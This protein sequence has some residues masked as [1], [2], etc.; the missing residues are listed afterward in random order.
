VGSDNAR[1]LDIVLLDANLDGVDQVS[2]AL[3]GYQDLDAVHFI[4]HGTDAAVKLGDT[5]LNLDN[6]DGYAGAIAGWN[7][8]LADDA[9]MLFYGCELAQSEDGKSLVDALGALTGADVAASVDDTGSAALGGDWE[10]EY[11]TGTIEATTALSTVD[12][13]NWSGLLNTFTVTN[14]NDS[15]AG[16]LRQAILDANALGGV[17]T[18]VFNIAATDV[19]H[20]YYQD[21][22]IAGSLSNPSTTSLADGSIVD[23]DP[24]YPG[25][26]HSWYSIKL[27]SVLPDITDPVI[28][29][30]TTQPGFAGTPI[31]ELDGTSAGGMDPNGLTLNAGNSTVRGFV[32]NRFADDGIELDVAGG[33]TIEG[34]YIGT[35]VTG[36]IA[37]GNNY[38][39]SVKSDGNIIGGTNPGQRNIIS[40]NNNWGIGFYVAASNNTVQGNYIGTDVVGTS[41]LGNSGSGINLYNGAANNTIGGITAGTGNIIANS[42]GNGVTVQN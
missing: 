36:T 31:I 34:N 24:D 15:G 32:I 9:D 42:A 25:S 8:A 6:I 3:A 37:L 20:F 39:I 16:S 11:T 23:F 4:T 28:L 10:L 21:D 35:D 18:I 13:Q 12:A 38:G 40:G 5:W 27:S 7:N 26:P 29:D 2:Q 14:T 1:R 17:D 19:N 30:A 22:S 33:N 41:A